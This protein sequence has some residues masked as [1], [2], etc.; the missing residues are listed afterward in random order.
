MLYKLAPEELPGFSDLKP[1]RIVN[2]KPEWKRREEGG[3]EERGKRRNRSRSWPKF[4]PPGSGERG[5]NA[6]ASNR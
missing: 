5:E 1:C 6:A 2:Y 4:R 3:R